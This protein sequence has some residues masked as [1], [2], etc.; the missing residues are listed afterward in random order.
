MKRDSGGSFYIYL[1]SAFVADFFFPFFYI[2][3]P[4]LAYHLGADP[5][6]IGLVGGSVYATYFFLPVMIGRFSDRLGTRRLFI[7]VALSI[8]ALVS[9]VYAVASSPITLIIGRVFEGVAW[10]ILWPTLM[11]GVTHGE[12]TSGDPRKSLSLYNSVWSGAAILGPP[13]GSLLVLLTSYQMTFSITSAMLA[14]SVAVNLLPLHRHR[15]REARLQRGEATTSTSDFG[16]PPSV[17]APHPRDRVEQVSHEAKRRRPQDVAWYVTANALS[18]MTWVI[19]FTFFSPYS[20]SIGIPVLL[21]GAIGLAAT[22][23][24]FLAYFATTR[25]TFRVRLVEKKTRNRNLLVLLLLLSLSSLLFLSPVHFLAFYFV[26]FAAFGVVD[27][28]VSTIAQVGIIAEATMDKAGAAAGL[29]ESSTG[30]VSLFG[31]VIAGAIAGSSLV[32]PLLFPALGIYLTIL[33]FGAV[34]LFLTLFRRPRSPTSG[35]G[36]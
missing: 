11:A 9:F 14:I 1:F 15:N 22:L 25:R 17:V 31:P 21:L 24:R 32:V 18:S 7:T 16:F 28:M 34:V 5:L 26:S 8:L 33:G 2:F 12:D 29:F 10:A 13:V 35:G 36:I 6:E 30:I 23:G 3:V 20:E 27:A 4:L 19:M